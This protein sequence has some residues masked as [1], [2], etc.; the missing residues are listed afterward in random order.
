MG[1]K[2]CA[3]L[4]MNC[5]QGGPKQILQLFH[6]RFMVISFKFWK[7]LPMTSIQCCRFLLKFH[8]PLFQHIKKHVAEATMNNKSSHKYCSHVISQTPLADPTRQ[9]THQHLRW[10]STTW[11]DSWHLK[12]ETSPY[13]TWKK[14]QETSW[15]GFFGGEKTRKRG[16]LTRSMGI[17]IISINMFMMNIAI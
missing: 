11:H 7:N 2:T 10:A 5:I 14:K 6:F 17:G 8:S 15:P 4:Y 9:A 1:A 16:L 3:N 12:G 13:D